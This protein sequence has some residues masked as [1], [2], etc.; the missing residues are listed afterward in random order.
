MS[1]FTVLVTDYAWQSL[2]IEQEVLARVDADLL[3][4]DGND[5]DELTRLAP[6]VD[7]ILT[8]WRQIPAEALDAAPRCLVISRFGIGVDN[9][10]VERA[11]ELGILVTNVPSFC[12]DEVSDH[13]MALLLACARRVAPLADS[14]RRRAWSL[15]PAQG[16]RRLRGQTLGII[17]FGA[18]AQ[19]LAPKAA[20][21]GLDVLVYTPRLDATSLPAGV[22]KAVTLEELLAGSDFVTLHAPATSETRGLIGERELRL[23]K[24]TA[25]LVN[26][27]RGA[28]VDEAALAR[29]VA[30]GWIAGA[31]LDVLAVEPPADDNP[32][33]CNDGVLVTPHSAFYSEDAVAEVETR[34]ADNVATVLSGRLPDAIV[35]PAVLDGRALRFRAR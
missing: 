20:A 30:D 9:I 35:N 27:A 16:M 31:A 24:P 18:I 32:L 2:R 14:V 4:A 15:E 5:P 29:A 28:L 25:Y 13:T 17:G 33:L 6:Q 23:M 3:V 11:T 19:A 8:N 26:T 12:I 1:R 34:A 22:T 10:P 21:F 7:A